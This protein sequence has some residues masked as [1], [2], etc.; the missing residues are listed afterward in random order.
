MPA[1]YRHAHDLS[2]GPLDIFEGAIKELNNDLPAQTM[3]EIPGHRWFASR[4]SLA[5]TRALFAL[6]LRD[7]KAL[8]AQWAWPIL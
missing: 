4:P 5:T 1:A 2:N 6:L 3:L 7:A 8:A